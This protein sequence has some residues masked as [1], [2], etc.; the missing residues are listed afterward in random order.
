MGVQLSAGNLTMPLDKYIRIGNINSRYWEEG[1]K[2]SPVILIHGLGA[3]AGSQVIYSFDIALQRTIFGGRA[4]VLD[5]IIKKLGNIIISTLII[6]D[7]QDRIFPVK[8]AFFAA[9]KL[10]NARLHIFDL[11]GHMPNFERP[12]EFNALVL[13]F[14]NDQNL[15]S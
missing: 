8:H 4:D 12:R 9:K 7:R 14:L 3:S 15:N 1:E 2:G 5:P 13:N 10:T 6:W 11:C